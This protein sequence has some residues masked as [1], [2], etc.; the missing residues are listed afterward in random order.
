VD[1]SLQQAAEDGDTSPAG[2]GTFVSALVHLLQVRAGARPA[3]GR[4][5]QQLLLHAPAVWD[6]QPLGAG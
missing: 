3:A 2:D 4:V 1:E 6:L 5:Q